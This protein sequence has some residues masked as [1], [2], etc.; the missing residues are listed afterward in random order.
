[1]L[2][3]HYRH[4]TFHTR[5]CHEIWYI[6]L[7]IFPTYPIFPRIF[8]SFTLNYIDRKIR[9][10]N[11]SSHHW[12]KCIIICINTLM[13]IL[14]NHFLYSL[15]ILIGI[16]RLQKVARSI[17]WEGGNFMKCSLQIIIKVINVKTWKCAPYNV[18]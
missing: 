4:N 18:L 11:T 9:L 17:C 12:I 16:L 6:I 1:M 5:T 3:G 14:T 7:F 10:C 2:L 13:Q 8:D 15:L